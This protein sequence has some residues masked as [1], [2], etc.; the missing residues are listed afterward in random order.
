MFE[1]DMAFDVI[2]CRIL[3]EFRGERERERERERDGVK[4]V[5]LTQFLI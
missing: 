4:T 2:I 1:I 5:F 3:L